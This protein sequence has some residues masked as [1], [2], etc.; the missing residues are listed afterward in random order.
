MTAQAFYTGVLYALGVA[1]FLLG[2]LV[3]FG[4]ARMWWWRRGS[5]W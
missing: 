5:R 1:I 3:L 4:Q 2:A